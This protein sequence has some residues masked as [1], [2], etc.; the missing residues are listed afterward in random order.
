VQV[1]VVA[2]QSCTTKEATDLPKNITSNGTPTVESK[3]N[4]AAGGIISDV[5]IK[6][7]QGNHAFFKDLEVRLIGPSGTDV[8]LWKDKCAAFNGNF[9][10]GMDDGATGAFPCPPPNTGVAYKPTGA[11]S[12]FN[13]QNS[14]GDWTLRVK[15]NTVSSGG[16]LSGFSL[17]ICSNTALAPPLIIVNNVLSLAPG[18]NASIGD[19]LLRADDPNNGPAS[20]T[21]TLMSLPKNGQLLINGVT[22]T[23]GAQF[24]QADISAGGLRYYDYGL[25]KGEDNFDFSVTDG[26]GGLDN[27]TY[28]IMPFAVGTVEPNAS[29]AFD[30][31]PNPASNTAV[32]TL[33]EP[34]TSDA[35]ITLLNA[36]GQVVTTWNLSTGA[37]TL[38]LDLEQL[39]KGVYAVSLQSDVIKGVKKLVIH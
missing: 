12:S 8:L 19:N 36:A 37:Y 22:A 23:I 38:R 1:F 2:I 26:E 34:L 15:D 17:E 33:R 39:P 27:D 30:L 21:F 5:N 16:A 13:G 9:N 28:V 31:S 32:L 4:I 14:A 20:L 25:N 35:R 7:I 10:L 29:L 18:T 3:I 6:K 11:L 24:T